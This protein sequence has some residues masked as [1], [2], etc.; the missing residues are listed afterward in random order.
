MSLNHII[1][2]S[3][4]T[5][6][7]DVSFA[8]LKVGGT[9]IL[10]DLDRST[11]KTTWAADINDPA[12]DRFPLYNAS[13]DNVATAV[14]QSGCYFTAPYSGWIVAASFDKESITR[15]TLF[16]FNG[17]TSGII[18]SYVM[19]ATDFSTVFNPTPIAIVA[20]ERFRLRTAGLTGSG[21]SGQCSANLFFSSKE[22]V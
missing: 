22:I 14:I 11:Y 16:E 15:E 13:A 5:P 7:L 18:L 19:G 12:A 10:P 6:D 17:S 2:A 1:D 9:P 20:G 21:L 8:S 3:S 4:L